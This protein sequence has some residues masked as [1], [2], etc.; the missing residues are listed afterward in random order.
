MMKILNKIPGLQTGQSYLVSI[1]IFL[2]APCA[3]CETLLPVLIL[4][5][6]F[7]LA[8]IEPYL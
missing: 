6:S 2:Q 5:F 8:Q 3:Y 1:L 7:A 4:R